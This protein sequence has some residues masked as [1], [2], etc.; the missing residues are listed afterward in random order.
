MRW[1]ACVLSG[2]L[3]LYTRVYA[4]TPGGLLRIVKRA[5]EDGQMTHSWG[6][7]SHIEIRTQDNFTCAANSQCVFAN[8]TI[9]GI[10]ALYSP[11]VGFTGRS[12]YQTVEGRDMSLH[13]HSLVKIECFSEDQECMAELDHQYGYYRVMRSLECKRNI[14]GAG[15]I[16]IQYYV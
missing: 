6:W 5:E 12:Y 10:R 14:R 7:K 13:A 1:L 15:G 16:N 4:V 8:C 9:K 11:T 3:I 2:I